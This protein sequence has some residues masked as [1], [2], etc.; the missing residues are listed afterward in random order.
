MLGTSWA[1]PRLGRS[2]ICRFPQSTGQANHCMHRPEAQC[3][4]TTY[5]ASGRFIHTLPSPTSVSLSQK[6]LDSTTRNNRVTPLLEQ[7]IWPQNYR[8][9]ASTAERSTKRIMERIK[10]PQLLGSRYINCGNVTN[11]NNTTITLNK[12]DEDNQISQWLSP[13]EPRHRHRS[14]Q[15]NRVEGVG[16]WLL[17]RNKFREWSSNQR[18]PKQA[19]LFCH[20]DPGVGK[21]HI[22]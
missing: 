4:L 9:I 21:T 8:G 18:A 16:G 13:L 19:V 22:R 10:N 17:E 2:Q 14:V 6:L 1:A 3:C 11:S 12:A 20:G 7:Y 15:T 5:C